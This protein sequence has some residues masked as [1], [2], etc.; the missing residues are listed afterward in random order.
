MEVLF[1]IVFAAGIAMILFGLF[2]DEDEDDR[3]DEVE[4][5]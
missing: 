1:Y 3:P 5:I 4:A 2:S